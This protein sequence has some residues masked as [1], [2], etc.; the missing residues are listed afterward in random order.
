[1]DEQT[2]YRSSS[3]EASVPVQKTKRS[4]MAKVVEKLKVLKMTKFKD[5]AHDLGRTVEQKTRKLGDDNNN[6][7]TRSRTF[8]N[9]SSHR[10]RSPISKSGDFG[11]DVNTVPPRPGLFAR[12]EK[13]LKENDS[14]VPKRKPGRPVGSGLLRDKK[15]IEPTRLSERLRRNPT[16]LAA[17]LNA[18]PT[19][20]IPIKHP[21]TTG[22][23]TR[24]K[25]SRPISSGQTAVSDKFGTGGEK[26]GADLG[27]HG[28]TSSK[29]DTV[30]ATA[31]DDGSLPVVERK[32]GRPAKSSPSND[33]EASVSS[34]RTKRSRTTDGGR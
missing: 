24:S 32:R 4:K 30:A 31:K 10:T 34:R 26:D 20:Q 27:H 33:V 12:L 5:K 15:R 28:R 1:M 21:E 23:M 6:S 17:E 16:S 8:V 14:E 3:S 7:T 18:L 25:R 13:K 11:V 19:P 29:T 2:I 9:T 22:W